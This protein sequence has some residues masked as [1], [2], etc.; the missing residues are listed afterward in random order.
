LEEAVAPSA[1]QEK[2]SSEENHGRGYVA[3]GG[4]V[5]PGCAALSHADESSFQQ[6][7]IGQWPEM[8]V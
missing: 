2:M 7:N 5:C 1:T 6:Q 3:K 8:Q 4:L